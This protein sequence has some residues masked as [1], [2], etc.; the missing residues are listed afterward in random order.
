[1][2]KSSGN[3]MVRIIT[4]CINIYILMYTESCIHSALAILVTSM[5]P[6]QNTFD[7]DYLYLSLPKLND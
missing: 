7:T 5:H 1:M 3:S 6:N 4:L 2:Y